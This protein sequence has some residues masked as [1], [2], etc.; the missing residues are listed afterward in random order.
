MEVQ[1]KWVCCWG[2]PCRRHHPHRRPPSRLC[3][4]SHPLPLVLS[5]RPNAPA[6]WPSYMESDSRTVPPQPLRPPCWTKAC[7]SARPAPCT[8]CSNRRGV[9]RAP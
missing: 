5:V 6:C 4:R 3:R 2:G 8:A 1:K 7:T 9:P